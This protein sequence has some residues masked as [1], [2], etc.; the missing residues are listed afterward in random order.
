MVTVQ[1]FEKVTTQDDK[2]LSCKNT[3]YKK[4]WKGQKF[5]NKK[6]TAGPEHQNE[7]AKI[8]LG[9]RK[10]EREKNEDYALFQLV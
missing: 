9:R 10:R 1:H 8:L 3:D 5:C 2:K 7:S 6:C 4:L